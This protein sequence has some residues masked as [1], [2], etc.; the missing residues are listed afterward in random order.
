MAGSL[1]AP[2]SNKM[3]AAC[4]LFPAFRRSVVE[5]LLPMATVEFDT[6]ELPLLAPAEGR[7][8]PETAPMKWQPH[9]ARDEPAGL[10]SA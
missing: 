2:R 4:N 7:P 1:S 6:E 5:G 9:H 8:T 10:G 3:F